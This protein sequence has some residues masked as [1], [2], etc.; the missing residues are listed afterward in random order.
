MRIYF[1]TIQIELLFQI[2]AVLSSDNSTA[3]QDCNVDEF[4][5]GSITAIYV[6]GFDDSSTS[7][8]LEDITG[9]LI[10]GL[11]NSG[12]G[13]DNTSFVLTGTPSFR[14]IIMGMCMCGM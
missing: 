13:I 1:I 14:S 11:A 5:N 3:L 9:T 10:A 2:I 4:R 12:F 7:A 8:T 6:L